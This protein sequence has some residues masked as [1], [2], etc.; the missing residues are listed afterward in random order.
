MVSRGVRL[1]VA[2]SLLGSL[3]GGC[4]SAAPEEPDRRKD[5]V[6]TL[7]PTR[8]IGTVG[9]SHRGGAQGSARLAND[10]TGASMLLTWRDSG[11]RDYPRLRLLRL[12]AQGEFLDDPLALSDRSLYGYTSPAA[13]AEGVWQI[14]WA[15]GYGVQGLRVD[16]LGNTVSYGPMYEPGEASV[17]FGAELASD[18]VR[19]W[20]SFIDRKALRFARFEADGGSVDATPVTVIAPDQQPANAAIAA[21]PTAGAP[22]LLA[23]RTGDPGSFQLQAS[24]LRAGAALDVPPL[25]LGPVAGGRAAPTAAPCSDGWLVAWADDAPGDVRAVVISTDG[26]VSA[27]ADVAAGDEARFAKVACSAADC[28]VIWETSRPLLRAR[29]LRCTQPI[30]F[31][32]APYALADGPGEYEDLLAGD[33]GYWLLHAPA[34]ASSTWVGDTRDLWLTLLSGNPPRIEN[35]RPAV[36]SNADQRRPSIGGSLLAW[37]EGTLD[38]GY[39]LFA[40]TVDPDGGA[41][42]PV[43]PLAAT[44]EPELGPQ[45]AQT[46]TGHLVVYNTADDALWVVSARAG[47]APRQLASSA[48]SPRAVALGGGALAVFRDPQARLWALRLSSDGAPLDTGPLLLASGVG[49]FELASNGSVAMA[50]F[51]AS[52]TELRLLRLDQAGQVMDPQ[53][54]VL[55]QSPTGLGGPALAFTGSFFFA[56]WLDTRRGGTSPAVLGARVGTGGELFDRAPLTL[57]GE[58][59][60]GV[61]LLA[62][63]PGGAW[64]TLDQ[65]DRLTTFRVLDDGRVS[66][67]VGLD[68][69]SIDRAA[70]GGGASA[71]L[72]YNPY[73][74]SLDTVRLA[75]TGLSAAALGEGCAESWDCGSGTCTGG[76]CA[77]TEVLTLDAGTPGDADGGLGLGPRSLVVGCGCGSARLP[78]FVALA[79][80]LARTL[81][82]GQRV[83]SRKGAPPTPAGALDGDQLPAL[84]KK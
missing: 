3:V 61:V 18:G 51:E 7:H 59:P 35:P 9:R 47:A 29:R 10:D 70:L 38:R 1:W 12:G 81:L 44:A 45:V 84:G 55:T 77:P 24:R 58:A 15:D 82:R 71:L 41:P 60:N 66:P 56:A 20:V 43:F 6:L 49:S 37:Q 8:T 28:L 13:F 68:V 11:L 26:G 23:W 79:A 83:R 5:A 46:S 54:L 30:T 19:N 57:L 72:A 76:R 80:L 53:G 48:L 74:A 42:G 63:A 39:D 32:E 16:R 67:G 31:V 25:A 27:M 78:P 64:L 33:A 40:A 73:V 65:P 2:V 22:L 62:P 17:L 36:V 52:P 34:Q 14:I 4:R 69:R 75:L 21:P 50:V